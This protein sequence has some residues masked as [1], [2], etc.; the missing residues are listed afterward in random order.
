MLQWD[1]QKSAKCL[2]VHIALCISN[3]AQQCAQSIASALHLGR[4]RHRIMLLAF[5]RGDALQRRL[6]VG[7]FAFSFLLLS[8]VAFQV[9]FETLSTSVRLLQEMQSG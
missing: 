2:F 5:H 6:L 8:L 9:W 1:V 4:L 7:H 3:A